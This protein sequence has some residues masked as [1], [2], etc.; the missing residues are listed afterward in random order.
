VAIVI[1]MYGF[2]E[3]KA[4]QLIGTPKIATITW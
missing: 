2:E 1:E 3:T 4:R